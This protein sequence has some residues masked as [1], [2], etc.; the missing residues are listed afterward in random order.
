MSE[1]ER[2][3]FP[4][5]HGDGEAA[6]PNVV[7]SVGTG[8][9]TGAAFGAFAAEDSP[10]GGDAQLS[11]TAK[12]GRFRDEMHALICKK[13]VVSG[14]DSS[15]APVVPA[16]G[17]GSMDPRDI[18]AGDTD[19]G[20]LD[21]NRSKHMLDEG[22]GDTEEA[23]SS[24]LIDYVRPE[25]LASIHDLLKGEE[26]DETSD[27]DRQK[28]GATHDGNRISIVFVIS[29]LDEMLLQKSLTRDLCLY[30][31]FLVLF[32]LFF[33][34]G[35]E[36]EKA[37]YIAQSYEDLL[38][39]NEFPAD[40]P[41]TM[42][43]GSGYRWPPN[44]EGQAAGWRQGPM[45]D[46][47]Y[48]NL[49]ASGDWH[50]WFEGVGVPYLW[51][52]TNPWRPSSDKGTVLPI[53]TGSNI[54]VGSMRIR[55]YRMPNDSCSV[56]SDVVPG[57]GDIDRMDYDARPNMQCGRPGYSTLRTPV[58]IYDVENNPELMVTWSEA[59]NAKT[60]YACQKACNSKAECTASHFRTVEPLTCNVYNTTCN[61]VALTPNI[62]GRT[63]FLLR[64]KDQDRPLYPATC[65]AEFSEVEAD[66]V[67]SFL[68]PI[69]DP[70]R[71]RYQPC[72]QIIGRTIDGKVRDTVYPCGGYIYD[73]PF[74]ISYD[75]AMEEAF[76]LRGLPNYT[77]HP[78]ASAVPV[79]DDGIATRFIVAEFFQYTTS[80]NYFT[81]VK[82]YT[83]VS[84]GG[85]WV[86]SFQLRNFRLWTVP[87]DVPKTCFD[88]FF[89]ILVFLYIGKFFRDWRTYAR[90]TRN[91]GKG[92]AGPTLDYICQAWNLLELI[93][94]LI[95]IVVF[96]FKIAWYTSSS[97]LQF[98]NTGFG[99]NEDLDY[100]MWLFVSS[101][102]INSFNGIF[103]FMK[104][105]KYVRLNDRFNI[106]SRTV[107]GAMQNLVGI[108]VIFIIILFAY[109]VTGNTLFGNGV[110]E[111]RSLSVA[112][113][114][115]L[116]LLLGDFDYEE[117]REENLIMAGFFFWTF[118]ILGLFLLLNFIIAVISEAFDQEMQKTKAPPLE[119]M[120]IRAWD[121]FTTML[122]HWKNPCRR[123]KEIMKPDEELLTTTIV[124]QCAEKW[125][126][127][128][129]GKI[130][131]RLFPDKPIATAGDEGDE[132]IE[133]FDRR[134]RWKENDF[135]YLNERIS[136]NIKLR[137]KY[138]ISY[139][140][141]KKEIVEKLWL[142]PQ[143]LRE[144]K[145]IE[146]IEKEVCPPTHKGQD[147]GNFLDDL[148]SV[149]PADRFFADEEVKQEHQHILGE[150][151]RGLGPRPVVITDAH[152]TAH[153]LEI[154]YKMQRDGSPKGE[155]HYYASP[156]QSAPITIDGRVLWNDAR[157]AKRFVLYCKTSADDLVPEREVGRIVLSEEDREIN[158]LIP[159]L[160][161]VLNLCIGPLGANVRYSSTNAQLCAVSEGNARAQLTPDLSHSFQR[162]SKR[163][164][165]FLRDI[166]FDI[167]LDKSL[168]GDEAEGDELQKERQRL[169]VS[170]IKS[171]QNCMGQPV[172][173]EYRVR[174][175]LADL[176][177]ADDKEQERKRRKQAEEDRER[178]RKGQKLA[179]E[180]TNLLRPS[181]RTAESVDFI[182]QK[183]SHS[184]NTMA[185]LCD[186][187]L[188]LDCW[189]TDIYKTYN[190][191]QR[192]GEEMA[193]RGMV[194]RPDNPD[195]LKELMPLLQQV[196][197]GGVP[198]FVA[199]QK[200]SGGVA[201]GELLTLE[202]SDSG[203]WLEAEE[204][205]D[206]TGMSVPQ[207]VLVGGQDQVQTYPFFFRVRRRK[208]RGE[209]QDPYLGGR[210]SSLW[211]A[212]ERRYSVGSALSAEQPMQRRGSGVTDA[213]DMQQSPTAAT[214]ARTELYVES[215]F[216]YGSDGL[217]IQN[218]FYRPP[219]Q[220]EKLPPPGW[221]TRFLQR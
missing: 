123:L 205:V 6:E 192:H 127:E 16:D 128:E 83:E 147:G 111:Y 140:D 208:G 39:G 198:Y 63:E 52:R 74:N 153:V 18:R 66:T 41:F 143:H 219:E 132:Q 33:Y 171:M 60:E 69:D 158:N 221:E 87:Y 206:V 10:T 109:S 24:A 133:E 155:L 12:S 56:N 44:E 138:S 55:V 102:Y 112:F 173:K 185:N 3:E 9:P 162:L 150:Q 47:V 17:S 117:L 20:G 5:D 146:K 121:K 114:T 84:A 142:G 31:P 210:R 42:Y 220:K 82:L 160:R 50:D 214:I 184:E 211:G 75:D 161:Q 78:N 8:S 141:L 110:E 125:L 89:M 45:W 217:P 64:V 156:E 149:R 126:V 81:A 85:S 103:C 130:S 113:S 191:P 53:G 213:S 23:G 218:M 29:Q 202:L 73:I 7:S 159:L 67:A 51:G 43:A 215:R 65:F 46:K 131:G 164:E 97:K 167:T 61:P 196:E 136:E 104:I 98:K 199:K 137:E 38:M 90:D 118:V 169:R 62:T 209:P 36:T 105:L 139:R 76:K 100:I 216:I 49:D 144:A 99:F 197:S 193:R 79:L 25:N 91:I 181:Q 68:G 129:I 88:V 122:S 148:Y 180:L 183:L 86:P 80:L 195:V 176:A 107:E 95:F 93:N 58:P 174:E 70:K 28:K 32:L 172:Q 166:W 26:D 168:K 124:Q 57:A 182:G 106:L 11:P 92:G 19:I 190:R 135:G 175:L 151:K 157:A 194:K 21:Q 71:F 119:E 13:L 2:G 14:V 59:Y 72:D 163:D 40:H 4:G 179:S 145:L 187:V 170:A 96:G 115:N 152:G 48:G 207:V 94:L 134:A 37:F 108:L 165:Q 188:H 22:G 35:R 34:L 212:E 54:L 186:M 200:Q 178:Q 101:L 189:L 27:R 30:V 1:H 201:M 154:S 120:V 116:R 77:K 203:D 177:A 204:Q 15:A